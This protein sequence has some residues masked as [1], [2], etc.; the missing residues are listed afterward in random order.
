[1][2]VLRGHSCLNTIPHR[3][4]AVHSSGYQNWSTTAATW[5]LLKHL[6]REGYREVAKKCMEIH[7]FWQKVFKKL[8][9]NLNQP[10]LNIVAFV[11]LKFQLK[12]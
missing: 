8:V 2:Q 7:P 1:M 9:L 4:S 11:L 3:G 6:G 5:A 12:K 10:E